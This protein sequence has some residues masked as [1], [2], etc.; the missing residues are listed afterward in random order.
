M[1]QR[2]T[3]QREGHDQQG[4][5][6][7]H[8]DRRR[9]KNKKRRLGRCVVL[10]LRIPPLLLLG[11]V[12][13]SAP[14]IRPSDGV[15]PGAGG[16]VRYRITPLSLS[17][18]PLRGIIVLPV[19]VHVLI[20]FVLP[21]STARF[22]FDVECIAHAK[23]EFLIGPRWHHKAIRIKKSASAE[24]AWRVLSPVLCESG[25]SYDIL[26]H[27]EVDEKGAFKTSIP[28]SSDIADVIA[29]FVR[30]GRLVEAGVAT[31]RGYRD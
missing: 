4:Y 27:F 29:Q 15:C 22:A 26:C 16:W 13:Q 2:R 31:I 3:A 7:I 11:P 21:M 9:R 10:A 30:A 28:V 20:R 5:P 18:G 6:E 12:Y 1:P 25:V 14:L 24:R 19:D 17:L 8:P 23:D